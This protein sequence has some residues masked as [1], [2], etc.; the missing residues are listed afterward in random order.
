MPERMAGKN[1]H[2]VQYARRK[3]GDPNR[4]MIPA[5]AADKYM[6][7]IHS[8]A[9]A[10][11]GSYNSRAYNDRGGDWIL[12]HSTSTLARSRCEPAA[13]ALLLVVSG[14][15]V[16]S[17]RVEPRGY[18]NGSEPGVI[19]EASEAIDLDQSTST[20]CAVNC[21]TDGKSAE[22]LTIQGDTPLATPECARIVKARETVAGARR[23]AR[24]RLGHYPLF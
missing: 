9:S 2:I 4:Q 21:F 10:D 24:F 20:G 16:I 18:A 23:P 3:N 1:S 7:L 8:P 11:V 12:I 15:T 13:P 17:S 14:V 5:M 22:M 6:F 19:R